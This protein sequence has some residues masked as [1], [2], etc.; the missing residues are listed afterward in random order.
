MHKSKTFETTSEALDFI[1]KLANRKPK[2]RGLLNS[3][4]LNG[5]FDRKGVLLTGTFE[6]IVRYDTKGQ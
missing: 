2:V 4:L 3:K 5:T 6:W 1:D